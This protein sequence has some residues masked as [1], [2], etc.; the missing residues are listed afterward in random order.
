[1]FEKEDRLVN[2]M[3]AKK[4]NTRLRY[5]AELEKNALLELV[6]SGNTGAV[7]CHYNVS[8]QTLYNW[9]SIPIRFEN[10]RGFLSK[11]FG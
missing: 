1:M 11:G 3:R 7:A 8:K 6:E 2:R 5:Y 9:K 10:C 4:K